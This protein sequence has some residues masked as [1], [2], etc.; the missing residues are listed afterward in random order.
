MVCLPTIS[1]WIFHGTVPNWYNKWG[2]TASSTFFE[3]RFTD[4][5]EYLTEECGESAEEAEEIA[6]S[7]IRGIEDYS[8]MI[9][10]C[11]YDTDFMM[12]DDYSAEDIVKS[13]VNDELGVGALEPARKR[14]P[15]G[16]FE[17]IGEPQKSDSF[18]FRIKI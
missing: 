2:S 16:S 10:Y 6:E 13:G 5:G 3:V 12:L 9:D 18:T 1:V 11:F 4:S 17:Y 14:L 7:R 15:D 8:G